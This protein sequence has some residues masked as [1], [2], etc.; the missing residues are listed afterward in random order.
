MSKVE[1]AFKMLFLLREYGMLTSNELGKRLGV[2]ERQIQKYVHDM[3]KAGIN[4]KSKLGN[5]GGYWI[6]ECPF[7]KENIVNLKEK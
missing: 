1:N 6:E 5:T 3:R 7:C 2:T 4:I